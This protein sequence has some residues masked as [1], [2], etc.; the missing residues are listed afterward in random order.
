MPY[1]F[2]AG[3]TGAKIRVVIIDKSTGKKLVPFDG[4]YNAA[5]V[6]KAQDG[7]INLRNMTNLTGANDGMAEYVFDASELVAG[8]TE[9]QVQVTRVSDG[10]IVSELQIKEWS[11][12]EK[13]S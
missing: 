13:L 2:V 10:K 12:L 6:V 8:K 4:V 1:D 3:D 11:V 5:I 9:T 7:T